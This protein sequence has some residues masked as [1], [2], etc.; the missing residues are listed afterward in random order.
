M[1]LCHGLSLNDAEPDKA[2]SLQ[3]GRAPPPL[4]RQ[5]IQGKRVLCRQKSLYNS[6]L[7]AANRRAYRC[8]LKNKK[9]LHFKKLYCGYSNSGQARAVLFCNPWIWR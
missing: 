3:A 9:Y 7:F 4:L 5:E 8:H 2:D 6:W 1:L